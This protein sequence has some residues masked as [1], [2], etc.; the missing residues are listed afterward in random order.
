[1]EHF[2][3][4][5]AVPS[6]PMSNY[7]VAELA[8]TLFED[9]GDALF[10]FDPESEQLL[11]VNPMALRL[12]GFG[13]H[14]L[15]RLQVTDLFRSE[16]PGCLDRLRQAFQKTG[17]FH[18]TEGFFLRHQKDRVWVPVNL[19]ITRLRAEPKTLGLITARDISE[20]K[21]T[22][23]ALW[24]SEQQFRQV[25]EQSADGMRLID[26][27]GRILQVN[28]AFCRMIEKSK[29]QLL[30]AYFWSVYQEWDRERIEW[31][32]R[33]TLAS[34]K[35]R[36]N[37][38]TEV[39]LWNNKKLSVELSN[40]L[41]EMAGHE[42]R[43]LS[44]FR[45]VT[46]RKHVEAELSASEA[47]YRTVLDNLEQHVFLKDG[48][49]RFVAA[50]PSFCRALD[51]RESEL[52]GKTDFDF[53]PPHL[54]EKY[55]AD[56]LIVLREGRHLEIE[57]ENP[58]Q[59]RLRTVRVV[60]TPVKDDLGR[61]SGVLGIFW[62]VTDQRAL[63]AQ[64]RQSQKMEAI[65]Q[66]AGGV[67]HDF[68]NLLTAILGNIALVLPKLQDIEP[69]REMLLVAEQA[70]LRAAELTRRLLGFSRRTVLQAKPLALSRT[71]EETMR[72]LRPTIDPRI[73]L[74]PRTD[75]DLWLVTAD[76]AQINQLLMNLCL[77]ARDA[78]P[79][80]GQLILEADNVVVG[81]DYLRLHLE[82]R[83]GEFVRLRV[84]D[85]GHGIPAE[86]RQRIFE[87]FF[88][89]KETGKG[90]G[91]GLAMVFGIVKQHRGWIDC[92]S[93]V[94]HGTCFD[95]YLPRS[96]SAETQRT[97]SLVPQTSLH[98]RETILLVDDEEMLRQL[99]SRILERYGYR[100]LLAEDGL[101]ALEIYQQERR[102]D[103]VILD[104]T[105]P[106]LSGPDTLKRLVEI[107][108]DARV[109]L[110]S[111]YSEE[112]VEASVSNRILGFINKPYQADDM[113]RLI[114]S[115][116]DVPVEKGNGM[117]VTRRIATLRP[118]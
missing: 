68:N 82:A 48:E 67:A 16:E 62:D 30:G 53:F 80:G 84:R 43:V 15:A 91:L 40:A 28:N 33:D 8:Q 64:L 7:Y 60:K 55:R 38:V 35:V 114:R 20:R 108:P 36:P 116:L 96:E 4:D 90:T 63:E 88:T 110:S 98:G 94:R 77:N 101:R 73:A 9:A 103:L 117:V 22:E 72:L 2:V 106:R 109:L 76:A 93:T 78:M 102:V 97:E 41:V 57:E 26:G 59:G 111:G 10:L 79:D 32:F 52:V 42:P 71:I 24:Q 46:A 61:I 5:S 83:A 39:T 19:T 99:A 118:R 23:E 14:E 107:N 29:T 115:A 113:V 1:M 95:V 47:K 54:A 44:I 58:S 56:D 17:I 92:E 85:T 3:I 31:S 51:R 100:V 105:M 86:I 34:G 25:W 11:D 65:G 18:G 69:Q 12:C 45:D 21:R 49:L 112:Q 104:L 81:H 6:H 13:R 27:A 50:N 74:D 66:L 70:A 37:F 75:P 87:P 89:T